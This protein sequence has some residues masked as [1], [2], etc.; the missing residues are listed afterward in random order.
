VVNKR[1]DRNYLPALDDFPIETQT[2][3]QKAKEEIANFIKGPTQEQRGKVE[4]ELVFDLGASLGNICHL[5]PICRR[6]SL[7]ARRPQWTMGTL[8]R[9]LEP[10]GQSEP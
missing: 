6:F 5:C 1:Q 7:F 2:A 9:I 3:D 4:N 10:Q 8:M